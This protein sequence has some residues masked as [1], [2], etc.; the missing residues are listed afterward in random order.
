MEDKLQKMEL[1]KAI[2]ERHSA[3][4]FTSKKPDWRD[5]LKA[6]DIARLIPLAGN[7]PTLKF[8]VVD[9]KEKIEKL[10]EAS[11]QDFVG[12]AKYIIVFC[13]DITNPERIYEERAKKYSAQQAG[14]A[15]QNFLLKITELGL[16][17][18]WI[19]AFSDDEVKRILQIPENIEVEALFPIGYEMPPKSKQRVKPDLDK[20]LYFNIWKNK[21]MI[22]LRKPEA[23]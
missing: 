21:Y 16:S 4:R 7:I 20:I 19:G 18:C 11:Q 15:I 9:D 2:K 5:I 8:I 1:D 14:S 13:S 22:P 3:R 23:L 17:T 6:L 10:S 12:T